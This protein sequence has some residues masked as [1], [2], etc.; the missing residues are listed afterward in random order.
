MG[1][2]L[3]TIERDTIRSCSG[4]QP[5]LT[6]RS[7]GSKPEEIAQIRYLHTPSG[8]FACESL[9]NISISWFLCSVKGRAL[10]QLAMSPK[11]RRT[12]LT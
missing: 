7:H 6:V 10:I 8:A 11:E 5:G 9:H 1:E 2:T 12:R 3:T 4:A